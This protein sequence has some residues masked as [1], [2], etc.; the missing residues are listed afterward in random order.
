MPYVFSFEQALFFRV[1]WLIIIIIIILLTIFG[2]QN[3]DDDDEV[4]SNLAFMIS[5]GFVFHSRR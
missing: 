3:C 4:Y 5:S 1:M 2:G